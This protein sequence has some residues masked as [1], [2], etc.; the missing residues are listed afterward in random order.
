MSALSWSLGIAMGLAAAV[1]LIRPSRSESA[2]RK[3]ASGERRVGRA[4]D[5]LTKRGV[6]VLHDRAMP[7]SKANIDHVAV[8]HSGV[9]VVAAKRYAGKLEVRSRGSQLW[10]NGRNRSQLLDHARNQAEV[11]RAI[12]ARAGVPEVPVTPVLCFVDTELPLLFPPKQVNGVMICT[13]KSLFKRII[14][15][16][17]STLGSDETVR[18]AGILD[19]ALGSAEG[20]V[21]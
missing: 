7:D 16:G 11:I 13:R 6:Y 9:F 2:W 17:P 3:G 15:R 10:I 20:T 19:D 14:Q 21:N 1:G 8:T 4:L 12:L 18:I 5:A